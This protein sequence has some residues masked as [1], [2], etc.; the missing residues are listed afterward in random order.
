MQAARV[1]VGDELRFEEAWG[2]GEAAPG[3]DFEILGGPRDG[4]YAELVAIPGENLYPRPRGLSWDEAAA[5]PLAGLTAYR[6][7]RPVVDT[8]F[9]LAEANSAHA[10]MA[11]GAQFGKLVLECG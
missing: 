7:R 11:A 4:T 3:P 9:P 10:R 6:A 8:T 1:H 5:F 2:A